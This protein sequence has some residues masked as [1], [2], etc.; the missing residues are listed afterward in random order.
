MQLY[1]FLKRC[2]HKLSIQLYMY[3]RKAALSA[4]T[5]EA[6]G[7]AANRGHTSSGKLSLLPGILSYVA[8]SRTMRG[9]LE[10]SHEGAER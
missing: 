2:G 4:E 3:G 1:D 10:S 7:F 8:G 6:L 9:S 5:L